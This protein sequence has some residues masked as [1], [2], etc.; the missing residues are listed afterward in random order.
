[1]VLDSISSTAPGPAPDGRDVAELAPAE[2]YSYL[3]S[4]PSGLTAGQAAV[5]L[6]SV[7]PNAISPVTRRRLLPKFASNFTHVMAILLWVGGAVAFAADLPQLGI[8]I[9]VVNVINGL[10]S[11]WQEYKAEKA[12]EALL[13]LLPV[14]ATVLRDG[15]TED[16]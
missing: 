15:V 16:V 3:G 6:E 5:R 7:G 8:A 14:T 13:K 9:W 4:S 10:F 12:T 2:V 11:F 1:V